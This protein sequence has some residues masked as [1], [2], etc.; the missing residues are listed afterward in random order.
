MAL[1]NVQFSGPDEKTVI[2]YFGD[3]QSASVYANMGTVDSSDARWRS[4][5]AAMSDAQNIGLRAPTS[6]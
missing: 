1:L 3:P 6:D 2:S 5:Y 4:F